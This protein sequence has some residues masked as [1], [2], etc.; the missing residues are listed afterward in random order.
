M[1]WC[2]LPLPGSLAGWLLLAWLPAWL[3]AAPW[4]AGW[5]VAAACLAGSLP[6]GCYLAGRLLALERPQKAFAVPSLA[7]WI[8]RKYHAAQ[9]GFASAIEE[10][11]DFPV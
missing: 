6:A 3:L 8:F 4:L 9:W 11:V 7:A 5:L 1:F 10:T 2:W